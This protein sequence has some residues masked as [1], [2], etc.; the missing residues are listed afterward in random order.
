[1]HTKM[2]SLVTQV[3]ELGIFFAAMGVLVVGL[4]MVR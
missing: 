1:M 4:L 3:A 2:L